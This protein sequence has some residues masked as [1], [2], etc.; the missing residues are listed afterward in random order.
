MRRERYELRWLAKLFG[1]HSRASRMGSLD[2]RA[3]VVTSFAIVVLALAASGWLF[4]DRIEAGV[5]RVDAPDPAKAETPDKPPEGLVV[6][7]ARTRG[8]L[9]VKTDRAKVQEIV[10]P[11][12]VAA[13][14][15]FDDRRVT[16]LKPRTKGRVTS[17]L[18]EPNQE[19]RSGQT[20][21]TLDASGVLDARNGLEAARAALGEA[22]A[23]KVA[24]AAAVKRAGALL[25]I[26]GVSPAEVER[27]QVEDAKAQAAVQSDQA[28]VDLYTAQYERLAPE[29][30]SST[31]AVVSP[32][33]GVVVSANLTVGDVVDTNQDAFT[34]A[35]PSRMLVLASLFGPDIGAVGSGDHVVVEAP[36]G[37]HAKFDAKIL[38]V[39]A[40]LDPLTN[41]ATARIEVANEK[42]LLK[43]N[44]FVTADIEADLHRRGVTIPA[45]S[46]QLTEQGPIAFVQVA[47]DRFE[48]RDLALGIERAD[49][50][51]VKHGVADGETV[52][53]SGSFGLKAILLRDL[54]GSTD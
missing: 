19:V 22:T 13:M 42:N 20:L 11:I 45:S 37:D 41:A 26:G 36:I 12:Q 34:V 39:G 53:T 38:T 14:V 15:A 24:S 16:R 2:M 10:K 17:L 43:A 18:V 5:D 29:A 47:P 25:K 33:T 44:M 28:Q 7:D 4:A 1:M 23:T 31:S 3:K 40:A 46:I 30:G 49:W 50:V 35:D 32:L 52:A 54:L 9:G 6:A 48:R 21:A 51:E 27:R 8:Q